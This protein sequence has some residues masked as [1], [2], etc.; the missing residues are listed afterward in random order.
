MIMRMKMMIMRMIMRE[1]G[2]GNKLQL[3]SRLPKGPEKDSYFPLS[4]SFRRRHHRRHH[5]RHRYFK[6]FANLNLPSLL[7]FLKNLLPPRPD[8]Q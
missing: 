3:V 8:Q 4:C 7:S 2:G 1:G 6:C 5:R